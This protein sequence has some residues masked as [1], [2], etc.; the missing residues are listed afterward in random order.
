MIRITGIP[1][2]LDDEAF[3]RGTTPYT[4]G[5]LLDAIAQQLGCEKECI[6]QARVLR[7]SVDARR[8]SNVH[9]VVTAAVSLTSSDDEATYVARGRAHQDTPYKPLDVIQVPAGN[10][11]PVVVGTGPAGLFAALYLARAGARPIVVERGPNVDDRAV[12]IAA[13]EQGG[14]LHEHANIQFG[15]G[16]AGTFSDGKLTT[17][18]KHAMRSHVPQWFVQAGAPESILWD[19][20]PHIGSDNLPLV[21][22]AM[23]NEIIERGG[24]VLFNTQLVGMTIQEGHITEVQV[25]S[26]AEK[27]SIPARHVVL[28]C[29]HSARDTFEML[30]DMGVAMK[31]KAFSIGVRIEHTQV[32]INRAQWGQ[33]ATHP[34]LGAA[35]Y[36]LVYHQPEKQSGPRVRSAYTFCMCPGGEVLCA[37]SEPENITTNGM[38]TYARDG[39]NANAALL[40][41]VDPADFEGDDAL[42]G[43]R[44]QQRIEQGAYRLTKQAGAAPYTAPAQTVGDFLANTSGNPSPTVVPSYARG[45]VWCN[46]RDVLPAYICDTMEEA[47]PA[48][49]RKLNGFANPDAVMTAPETRSSSPVCI[50]RHPDNL[51]AWLGSPNEVPDQANTIGLYPCGEGAGYAGGIMSAACDGLRVGQTVAQCMMQEKV[52]S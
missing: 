21:V 46:L 4:S 3:C 27:R 47:L 5:P 25:R 13:F 15:E 48:F 50:Q 18:I 31:P 28:A 6:Q 36:K 22:A 8:K 45:V 51:Q 35:E 17:N 11:A 23:R 2:S 38:S 24:Q 41:A 19:A 42:A 49:D 33:A 52:D 39:N 26:S 43:V 12:A 34:A 20:R 40:V 14:A 32:C 7:R 9:F 29:G 37:A 10:L 16:G 1:I 30:H 44:L